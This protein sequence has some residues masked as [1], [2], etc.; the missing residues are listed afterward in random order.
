M[1]SSFQLDL[2]WVVVNMSLAFVDQ[3]GAS[4]ERDVIRR[5]NEGTPSKENIILKT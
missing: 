1:L 4:D 2:V 5:V 3:T